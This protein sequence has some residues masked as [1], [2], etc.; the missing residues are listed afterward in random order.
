M[1]SA[2]GAAVICSRVESAKRV[3]DRGSGW[4]HLLR[5]DPFELRSRSR[6]VR[7]E[8]SRDPSIDFAELARDYYRAMGDHVR[9]L[10]ASA[11]GVTVQRLHSLRVGWSAEHRATTWPMTDAAG[12]VRGIRLRGTDGRKWA[13][14]GG[15]EGLFNP[16]WCDRSF[17]SPFRLVV[18]EGATDTAALTDLGFIAIGR[19]SCSGGVH[20]I[21]G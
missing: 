8:S 7:V 13:V 6:R 4:L 19:P 2:D 1:V 5:D 12:A 18:C 20:L 11:L 3:G 14:R 17:E 16:G 21:V 15:R 9:G 10:T